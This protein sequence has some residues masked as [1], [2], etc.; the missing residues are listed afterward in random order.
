M[1]KSNFVWIIL[2]IAGIVGAII[3]FKGAYANPSDLPDYAFTKPAI[4]DA[5]TYAKFSPDALNGLPCHCGCATNAMG[6][7]R[8][9]TRGLIDC[10]M[11]G[12]VNKGGSWDSHAA[13][14]VG[15]YEDA[16]YSKSLYEQGKNKDEI[17][18]ALIEKYAPKKTENSA[19]GH[20]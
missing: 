13:N 12:D 5:Y 11:N 2:L 20:S 18:T 19:I 10:F 16:L 8:L 15:C 1:E 17:K 3:L 9:H 14:C 6:H 4:K 7:G